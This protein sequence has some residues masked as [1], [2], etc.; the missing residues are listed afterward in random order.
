VDCTMCSAR[1]EPIAPPIIANNQ[2]QC[3]ALFCADQ[4]P[5]IIEYYN[6]RG[7][8][9]NAYTMEANTPAPSTRTIGQNA[10]DVLYTGNPVPGVPNVSRQEDNRRFTLEADQSC[11]WKVTSMG[12]WHS[13][14]ASTGERM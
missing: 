5:R 12:E 11:N 7:Q 8:W 4:V 2:R 10:C 6:N 9:A 14:T 1:S 3:P 13:G